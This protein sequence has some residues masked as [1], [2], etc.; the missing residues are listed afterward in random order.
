M[1]APPLTRMLKPR[2]YGKDVQG[3]R[4]I[5][6]AF[7]QLAPPTNALARQRFFGPGMT[8]LLKDAA[9]QAGLPKYGVIGPSSEL[10]KAFVDADVASGGQIIDDYARQLLNQHASELHGP[11]LVF[12]KLIASM[13][14]MTRLTPGYQLGGGHGVNLNNLSKAR[15]LDCSSS[16]SLALFDAGMFPDDVAWVSGE[17][18]RSWGEPGPGRYFTVY[19]NNEHVWIRLHR[20]R[21]WRFDTS[22]HGDGGRGPQLRYLPR[23]TSGFVARHWKGM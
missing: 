5:A 6:R 12:S 9:D 20:S 2:S 15:K 19:A 11:D 4:R 7:C 10:W 17:I 3:V 1:T 22:P 13:Q 14:E 18:A 8:Q 21:W 16:T 23:R